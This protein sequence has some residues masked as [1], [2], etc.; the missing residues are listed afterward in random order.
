M[1]KLYLLLVVAM[2]SALV[3]SACSTPAA[4]PAGSGEGAAAGEDAAATGD[5]TLDMWSFT[6]ELETMAI[7]YEGANP[8]V[9]VN[10]TMIPMTAGEYQTKLLASLGT[11]DAPDVIA[12]EAAFVKEYIESDFLADLGALL[13]EA[14]AAG[15]YPFVLE[16]GTDDGVTKAYSFQATPGALFLSPQPRE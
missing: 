2:L 16:V 5:Q 9:D 10:Y 11:A 12:L 8:G 3:L 14:E 1:R 15:T 4:A 6:N 7:A 13:P